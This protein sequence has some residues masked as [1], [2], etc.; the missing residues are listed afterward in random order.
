MSHLVRQICLIVIWSHRLA[1]TESLSGYTEVRWE[2]IQGCPSESEVARLVEERLGQALDAPREQSLRLH[3]KVSRNDA[4]EYEVVLATEGASGRGQRRIA[5]SDCTK[6]AEAT[7]LVMAIA[8][9]PKQV[10]QLA[11]HT[12][13]H[14][15]LQSRSEAPSI[16]AP[17]SFEPAAAV[18][19]TSRQPVPHVSIS[20]TGKVLPSATSASPVGARQ[21]GL[22]A[23]ALVGI[24]I[25]PNIDLGTMAI[26]SYFPSTGSE[27]RI[28]AGALLPDDL[29]IAGSN[30][31]MRV[32]AGFLNAS[33]C[34][35]PTRQRWRTHVCVGAE[36]G[37]IGAKGSNLDND[38]ST[39]ATLS[40]LATE[41][42][43]GYRLTERFGVAGSVSAGVGLLRPRFGVK[44]DGEPEFVYQSEPVAVRFGWGVFCDLP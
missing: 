25:L 11:Q 41:S 9:D 17:T 30:G 13:G 14:A 23:T 42:G 21:W 35:V 10:E 28:G 16:D 6:L 31:S 1:A 2:A 4:G 44:R 39:R 18:S 38:R 5:N 29:H 32:T 8:I 19:T 22:G 33:V 34:F 43:L 3:A 27:L 36:A 15:R 40:S 37:L 20:L 26:L 7:A 12:N 24:G